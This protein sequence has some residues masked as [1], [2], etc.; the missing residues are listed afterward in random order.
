MP[1]SR[2]SLRRPGRADVSRRADALLLERDPELADASRARGRRDRSA[3]A[4]ARCST[5]GGLRNVVRV[6]GLLPRARA[7]GLQQAADG[8]LLIPGGAD[9]TT[10]KVFEYLAARK[11]IFAVT[12]QHS[13]AAELLRE[14]GDHT[15]ADPKDAES[16][17]AALQPYLARWTS[18]GASYRTAPGLRPRSLRIRESRQEALAAA[19]RLRARARRRPR[20][21]PRL[22]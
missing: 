14:A 8:L 12:E 6:L 22:T 15:V 19:H 2:C 5:R 4:N 10:A 9:A 13:V 11:P 3:T 16:L 17:A 18:E 1:T 21:T 20:T 7:L